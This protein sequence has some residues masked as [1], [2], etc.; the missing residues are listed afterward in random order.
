MYQFSDAFRKELEH[1]QK[2]KRILQDDAQ[3]HII[4][5]GEDMSVEFDGMWKSLEIMLA[6]AVA[7]FCVSV[8]QKTNDAKKGESK[9][10]EIYRVAKRKMLEATSESDCDPSR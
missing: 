1:Q 8:I 9:L 7:S 4:K 2:L 6:A 10:D 5:N 3:I